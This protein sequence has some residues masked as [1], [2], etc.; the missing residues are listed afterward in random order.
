MTSYKNSN[1]QKIASVELA[2]QRSK[3]IFKLNILHA[4]LV[5]QKIDNDPSLNINP[6]RNNSTLTDGFFN[7]QVHWVN[8][9]P[10]IW[11]ERASRRI[12]SNG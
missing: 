3:T 7:I 8:L 9:D 12:N 1:Q 6:K 4:M 5:K 10:C 11:I 2:C